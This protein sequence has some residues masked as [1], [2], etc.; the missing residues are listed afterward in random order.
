MGNNKIIANAKPTDPKFPMFA[1]IVLI[2]KATDKNK[3]A[4]ECAIKAI[5]KYAADC[6]KASA[7]LS[8]DLLKCKRKLEE[9]RPV[10]PIV[11]K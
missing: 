5:E 10:I 9:G 3:A 2:K 11:K 8:S 7:N 4:L 1:E 6:A